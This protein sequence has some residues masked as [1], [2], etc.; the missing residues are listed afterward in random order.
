LWFWFV[1]LW[2]PMNRTSLYVLTG[3]FYILFR[4]MP[5]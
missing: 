5:T 2:C 4:G 3:H 1:L